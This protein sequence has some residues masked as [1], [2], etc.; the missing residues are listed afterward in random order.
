MPTEKRTDRP[1]RISTAPQLRG[2]KPETKPYEVSDAKA[3]GLR[4]RVS[5]PAPARGG[6]STASPAPAPHPGRFGGALADCRDHLPV[7]LALRLLNHVRSRVVRA[8]ASIQSRA[9]RRTVQTPRGPRPALARHSGP[10]LF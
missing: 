10:L 2:L 9:T 7:D 6:T 1:S 5:P 4:L 3:S 8:R